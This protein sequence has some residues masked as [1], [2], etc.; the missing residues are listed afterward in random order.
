MDADWTLAP[1]MVRSTNDSIAPVAQLDR[2]PGYELGG[3]EFESLR[4][5]HSA[6]KPTRC[7]RLL[8][9]R[10]R[11]F[12]RVD[13]RDRANVPLLVCPRAC[14]PRE[15]F[16]GIAQSGRA[17]ALGAGC[18]G[19]ESLCPDHCCAI[20]L[21]RCFASACD[22]RFALSP[23]VGSERTSPVPT[24]HDTASS[25][26]L[27]HRL[28]HRALTR[29][30]PKP[31]GGERAPEGASYPVLVRA[32]PLSSFRGPLPGFIGRQNPGSAFRMLRRAD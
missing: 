6:K 31:E 27:A 12:A 8:R 20:V 1:W 9:F 24:F 10:K 29:D 16:R 15:A 5:R 7:R 17:P 26:V 13:P 3:R 25:M 32:Y 30:G 19:F 4:A 21:D 18:R 2:V 11:R 23:S 28:E 22:K 14:G